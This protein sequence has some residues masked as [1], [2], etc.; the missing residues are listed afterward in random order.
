[1]FVAVLLRL[2][3]TL[4]PAASAVALPVTCAAFAVLHDRLRVP[5]PSTAP[6]SAQDAADSIARHVC[7]PPAPRPE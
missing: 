1:M 4:A 3:L 2:A 5:V 6:R 7:S